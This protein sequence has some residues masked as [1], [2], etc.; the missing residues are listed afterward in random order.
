[1]INFLV[2]LLIG[3]IVAFFVNQNQKVSDKEKIDK[4][5][6]RNKELLEENQVLTIENARY[7]VFTQ[8]IK[9]RVTMLEER[10]N[11]I[12]TWFGSLLKHNPEQPFDKKNIERLLANNKLKDFDT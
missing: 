11:Q 6:D 4:L 2:G 8:T 7:K 3:G 9:D 12:D 1:M 5:R 10:G